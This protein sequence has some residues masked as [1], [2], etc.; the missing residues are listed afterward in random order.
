MTTLLI[1]K[2]ERGLT[3]DEYF[4]AEQ[5]VFHRHEFA[6]GCM[7][8]STSGCAE[9]HVIG[10]GIIHQLEEL[11]PKQ[12]PQSIFTENVERILDKNLNVMP[13]MPQI[14]HDAPFAIVQFH[15]QLGLQVPIPES[16]HNPN[17][18]DHWIASLNSIDVETMRRAA[19]SSWSESA[20]TGDDA[21]VPLSLTSTNIS[22]ARV[23]RFTKLLQ[24]G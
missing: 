8:P 22:L 3:V 15:Y 18:T 20:Y 12:R 9:D 4:Q 1:F 7:T 19:D 24:R 13:E 14:F 17:C 11:P 5:T 2:T 21:I 23:Y 6:H 16:Y 10:L